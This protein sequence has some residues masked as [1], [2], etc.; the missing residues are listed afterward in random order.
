MLVTGLKDETGGGR[1]RETADSVILRLD[2]AGEGE[3]GRA[4]M[5]G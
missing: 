2:E 3:L 4:D 5:E 1:E